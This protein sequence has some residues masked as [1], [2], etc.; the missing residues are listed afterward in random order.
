M[1]EKSSFFERYLTLLFVIRGQGLGFLTRVPTLGL[2]TLR[3][4]LLL[5]QLLGEL[6]PICG[7]A[8][9]ALVSGVSPSYSKVPLW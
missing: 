6:G 2:L 7:W 1:L 5:V 3:C 4:C 8:R 9:A